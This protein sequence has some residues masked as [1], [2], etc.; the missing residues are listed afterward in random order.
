MYTFSDQGSR[1]ITLRPEG[2]SSIA[3]ALISNKLHINNKMNRLWYLGPMFRYERPQKGRQRQF[4]QLGI[5]CIGSNKPLAD[6]E[7]IKLAS[8]ILKKLDCY[9]ECTLEINSIGNMQEREVY[10][11]ELTEYLKKYINEL[12]V[13]SQKRI[14]N[15]PSKNIRYEKQQNTRNFTGSTFTQS[16]SKCII[17]KAL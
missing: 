14:L 6:A 4:H 1:S 11:Q 2:T 5:E 15:K 8:K 7:V 13:D 9:E 17:I 16:L 10:K 3:R 12:D